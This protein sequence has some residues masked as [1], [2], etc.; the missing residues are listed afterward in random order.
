MI[1]KFYSSLHSI[2][3]VLVHMILVSLLCNKPTFLACQKSSYLAQRQS[4]ACFHMSKAGLEMIG[5]AEPHHS[6][7]EWWSH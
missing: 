7:V 5:Q 3:D 4:T 2:Y 6:G 1:N